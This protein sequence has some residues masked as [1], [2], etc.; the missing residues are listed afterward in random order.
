MSFE[1]IVIHRDLPIKNRYVQIP[2]VSQ[3]FNYSVKSI[4]ALSMT[5]G[6]TIVRFGSSGSTGSKHGRQEFL[7]LRGITPN[8]W[9]T[10]DPVSELI[11]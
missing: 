3:M 11:S 2:G 6:S 9:Y 4:D 7:R 1:T 8:E 10:T 5:D